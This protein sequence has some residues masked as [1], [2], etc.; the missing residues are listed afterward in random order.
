MAVIT[1]ILFL[2]F[3]L[4][5]GD[6]N[7]LTGLRNKEAVYKMSHIQWELNWN[8]FFIPFQKKANLNLSLHLDTGPLTLATS[9]GSINA[10]RNFFCRFSVLSERCSVFS[11]YLFI[12]WL[13]FFLSCLHFG[14]I[15]L[16][17]LCQWGTPRT[18]QQALWS[19]CVR[20]ELGW[21]DPKPKPFL[22]NSRDKFPS[23]CLLHI[24]GTSMNCYGAV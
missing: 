18:L 12:F 8:Y 6:N 2:N 22:F 20:L 14:V 13:R 21:S 19:L 5:N 11:I 16:A 10:L 17:L 4:W 9:S 24:Y 3:S 1:I 7:T 23:R 15:V